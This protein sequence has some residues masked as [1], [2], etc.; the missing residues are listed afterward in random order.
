M[1]ACRPQQRGGSPSSAVESPM[2]AV[3]VFSAVAAICAGLALQYTWVFYA[4]LRTRHASQFTRVS[5]FASSDGVLALNDADVY[6]SWRLARVNLVVALICL[7]IAA[8]ATSVARH[9]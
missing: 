5:L 4:G 8:A 3:L 6:A 9:G 2:I 1:R 7:C